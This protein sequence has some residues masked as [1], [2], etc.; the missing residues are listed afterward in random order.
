MLKIGVKFTDHVVQSALLS[1]LKDQLRNEDLEFIHE[2]YEKSDILIT[3]QEAFMQTSKARVKLYFSPHESDFLNEGDVHL[4][5][6]FKIASLLMP[7]KQAIQK[8]T[9]IYVA[10]T[11]IIFSKVMKRIEDPKTGKEKFL[12]DKENQI[13]FILN[14]S[15]DQTLSKEHLLKEIWKFSRDMDTHTLETHIYRLRQ[16]L[17]QFE[18]LRKKLITEEEGYKLKT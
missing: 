11:D 9:M 8:D 4:K 13:L 14:Q 5:K 6:P 12:T 3:D 18:C 1:Y 2:T 7:I 10:Q 15:L 17:D 16:K